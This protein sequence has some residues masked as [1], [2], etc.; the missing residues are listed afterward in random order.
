MR[1]GAVPEKAALVATVASSAGSATKLRS[2]MSGGGA[3]ASVGSVSPSH[4]A[5]AYR[6]GSPVKACAC[7]YFWKLRHNS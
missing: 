2:E 5:S 4:E 6:L 1:A 7:H 3:A